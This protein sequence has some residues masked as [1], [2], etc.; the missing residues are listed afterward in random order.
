MAGTYTKLFYH[1]VFSTKNRG[2]FI[3]S[4]IED[5]LHKY[6]TGIGP[7]AAPP[8]A[9]LRKLKLARAVPPCPE[10]RSLRHAITTNGS[11]TPRAARVHH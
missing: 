10:G 5:E 11:T 3:T 2:R 4:T 1:I 9:T 8:R 6:I 7:H